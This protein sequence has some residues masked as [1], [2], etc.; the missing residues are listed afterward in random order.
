M[1]MRKPPALSEADLTRQV[2]DFMRANGWRAIR[3]QR[4]IM[5]GQFQTGEPGMPDYQFIYYLKRPYGMCLNLFVEFKRKSN[6]AR[7]RCA[8]N[9]GTRRRC[10]FHDQINWRHRESGLGGVVWVVSDFSYFEAAY[11]DVFASFLAK[12]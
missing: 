8:A 3:H 5:K 11:M 7:C 1:K 9:E 4:T 2:C 12:L 10:T 6:T